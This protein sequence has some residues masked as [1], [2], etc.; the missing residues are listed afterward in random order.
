[1]SEFEKALEEYGREI[2]KFAKE[3]RSFYRFCYWT[4]GI[5]LL[6]LLKLAFFATWLTYP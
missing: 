6:L 2:K 5:A 1:M 4:G 3:L